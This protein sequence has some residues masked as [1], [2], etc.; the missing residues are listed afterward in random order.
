MHGQKQDVLPLT[1]QYSGR[2]FH[3]CVHTDEFRPNK[4]MCYQLRSA[5][6][7]APTLNLTDSQREFVGFY[8]IQYFL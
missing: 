7:I 3:V 6:L 4:S 2:L 5:L 1:M 8:W